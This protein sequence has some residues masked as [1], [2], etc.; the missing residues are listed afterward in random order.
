MGIRRRERRRPACPARWPTRVRGLLVAV[1]IGLG[2]SVAAEVRAQSYIVKPPLKGPGSQRAQP[3]PPAATAK[4]NP[5]DKT[6][7][8]VEVI[9]GD[10]GLGLAAQQW[11]QEFAKLGV[12]LRVRRAL[13]TDK[14]G[15]E[16]KTYGTLRQVVVTAQLGR[17]GRIGVNGRSFGPGDSAKLDEWIRELKTYGGQGAPEGQPQWGLSAGQF[18]QLSQ[19]LTLPV[20]AEVEGR[21]LEEAVGS[22][23][24]PS[25]HPLRISTAARTWLANEYGR[26]LA[27]KQEVMGISRGTALA[28]LLNDFGL[29]FRPL[30]T[31][32]GEIELSIEPLTKTTDLWPV[33]WPPKDRAALAAPKLYE[34]VTAGFEDAKFTDV[35]AAMSERTGVP[36]RIDRFRAAAIDVDVDALQVTYPQRRTTWS[37]LLRSIT[38][39]AKLSREVRIDEAGRP[40]V[41]IAPIVPARAMERLREAENAR[42]R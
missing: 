9:S 22:L 19:A 40:F 33:G 37:L 12:A 21:P 35:L 3:A 24:V 41:W 42:R 5:A 7:V 28:I 10:G 14:P 17:D 18:S 29:G 8:S 30:R 27:V 26:D 15:I 16:E 39:P 36:V 13:P 6:T 23:G 32:A 38:V 20:A 4:D 25:E 11:Q 31:P 1:T 2:A 34:F